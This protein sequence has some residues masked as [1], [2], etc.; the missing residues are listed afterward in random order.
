MT[1]LNASYVSMSNLDKY[2]VALNIKEG[3]ARMDI[4]FGLAHP[5]AWQRVK[6]MMFSP[7]I[8]KVGVSGYMDHSFRN[9]I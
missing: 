8:S 2:S 5:K 3:Y 9:L 7:F 1:N 6:V 4:S